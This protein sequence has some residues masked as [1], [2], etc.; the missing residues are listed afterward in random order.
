MPRKTDNRNDSNEDGNSEK[1][2]FQID[3]FIQQ[4]SE[5]FYMMREGV[6]RGPFPTKDDAQD[7][8]A[9]LLMDISHK[10][11]FG[12]QHIDSTPT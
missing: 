6:E 12:I 4:N 8:L 5:W 2:Y 9:S 7:D 1:T 3:R 11:R 10:E